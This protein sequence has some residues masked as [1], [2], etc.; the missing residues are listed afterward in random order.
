MSEEPKEPLTPNMIASIMW[1]SAKGDPKLPKIDQVCNDFPTS[2][3]L[4]CR[5]MFTQKLGND[6]NHVKKKDKKAIES[7]IRA[8]EKRYSLKQTCIRSPCPD[9][10]RLLKEEK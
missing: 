1:A 3:T 2:V 4:A 8:I 5:D 6:E 9:I 7:I 10:H